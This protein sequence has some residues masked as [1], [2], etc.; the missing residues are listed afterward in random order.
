MSDAPTP[1]GAINLPAYTDN[2]DF[3]TTILVLEDGTQVEVDPVAL[4]IEAVE[5]REREGAVYVQ[6]LK[7]GTHLQLSFTFE[8][9]EEHDE[10]TDVEIVKIDL[11]KEPQIIAK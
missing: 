7:D 4:F 11:R 1:K 2:R 8:T 5:N 3:R 9:D 10:D 6:A